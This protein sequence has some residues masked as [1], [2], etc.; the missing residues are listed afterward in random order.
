[1]KYIATI[2]FREEIEAHTLYDARVIAKAHTKFIKAI[3]PMPIIYV[4]LNDIEKTEI[5]CDGIKKATEIEE[6]GRRLATNHDTLTG[7]IHTTWEGN[8]YGNKK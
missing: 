7:G 2:V 5:K 8:G 3:W 4:D 1:M 6:L